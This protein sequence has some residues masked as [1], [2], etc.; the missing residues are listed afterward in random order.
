MNGEVMPEYGEETQK[1]YLERYESARKFRVSSVGDCI[2]DVGSLKSLRDI[3]VQAEQL[4]GERS[5]IS[6]LGTEPISDLNMSMFHKNDVSLQF[7]ERKKEMIDMSVG[8]NVFLQDA[9]VSPQSVHQR[10]VSIDVERP[11]L[12]DVSVDQTVQERNEVSVQYEAGNKSMSIQYDMVQ[13]N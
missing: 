11:I 12:M 5:F 6:R 8:E 2:S 3:S 4:L 9:S 1:S 7:D 13:Q 10:D